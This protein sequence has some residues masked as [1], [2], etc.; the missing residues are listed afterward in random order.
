LL[1]LLV[2]QDFSDLL[3]SRILQRVKLAKS[4]PE[5]CNFTFSMSRQEEKDDLEDY[6]SEEPTMHR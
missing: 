4:E 1:E 6:E 3:V 2:L 5:L